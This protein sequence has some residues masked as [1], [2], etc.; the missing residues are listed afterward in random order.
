MKFNLLQLIESYSSLV[1]LIIGILLFGAVIAEM[2]KTL[3]TGSLNDGDY[4]VLC[5]VSIA[6]VLSVIVLSSNM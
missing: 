2:T 3:I 4:I 5:A 6:S 1:I